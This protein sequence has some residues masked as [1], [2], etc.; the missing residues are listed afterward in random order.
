MRSISV[1]NILWMAGLVGHA[2]LLCLLIARSHTRHFPVFTTLVGYNISLSIFLFL[3]YR[4]GSPHQQ[5]VY[6]WRATAL[7][8][9]LEIAFIVEL[10]SAV[11]RASG[12]WMK[13]AL[14]PFLSWSV[15]ALGASALLSRLL[16]ADKLQ[17]M[18]L[19]D[20]RATYFATSLTCFLYFALLRA[21]NLWHLPW[22]SRV[23]VL[24]QGFAVWQ[25]VSTLTDSAH[26]WSGWHWTDK[27]YDEVSGVAYL[28][29]LS[30][31]IAELRFP[32]R[33]VQKEI[34]IESKHF[35]VA[36]ALKADRL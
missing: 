20:M 4:F 18:D 14:V 12:L 29:I 11:M 19:W 31:W 15:A 26:L 35:I 23:M 6:Y 36:L 33:D 22:R 17:G 9:V 27:V 34:S 21:V 3:L 13:K 10:A 8:Y 5:Y 32:E 2:I 1:E 25:L 30:Y 24:G 28:A 16:T 7:E